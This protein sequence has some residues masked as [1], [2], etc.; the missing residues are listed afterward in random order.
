MFPEHLTFVSYGV[1]QIAVVGVGVGACVCTSA[2]YYTT[3]AKLNFRFKE[4]FFEKDTVLKMI[5][6]R[7]SFISFQMIRDLQKLMVHFKEA[8]SGP[9]LFMRGYATRE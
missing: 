1:G 7:V 9:F 5:T 2:L 3:N 8:L 6:N 4:Q